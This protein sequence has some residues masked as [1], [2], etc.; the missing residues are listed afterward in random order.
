MRAFKVGLLV[1]FSV[2]AFSSS[3]ICAAQNKAAPKKKA[4][5]TPKKKKTAAANRKHRSKAASGR[6]AVLDGE[7]HTDSRL[8]ATRNLLTQEQGHPLVNYERG[9][10]NLAPLVFPETAPQQENSTRTVRTRRAPGNAPVLSIAQTVGLDKVND[11]LS[12]SSSAVFVLDNLSSE[13]LFQKNADISLP[14]ASITKLMTALVVVESRQ[15]MSETIRITRDDVANMPSSRLKVGT[16]TTRGNLL[17]LALMSSENSAA[18]ALGRNYPGGLSAFVTAMNAKARSLGMKQSF[19]ADTTGLSRNN[20]ASARDLVKLV[21]AAAKH[22][23]LKQFSTDTGYTVSDGVRRIQ[24]SNT[25]R[26]V[27]NAHM[28]IELQ[29]TGFINAAGNCVVL[30]AVVDERRVTMIFLDAKSRDARIQDVL[31]IRNWI[32]QGNTMTDVKPQV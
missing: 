5:S 13:V 1:L 22:P 17:H 20:V 7:I 27:R 15:N 19:Y 12:L 14:I 18:V 6:S 32:Q 9:A 10:V 3:G 16:T 8:V 31:K 21:N 23:I 30:Q 26:L 24:Y 4:I 11:P 28:N 29:K 2:L 25:N